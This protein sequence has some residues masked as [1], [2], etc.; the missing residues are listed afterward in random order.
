MNVTYAEYIEI[1]STLENDLN[2]RLRCFSREH[3]SEK[4]KKQYQYLNN[5][6][7]KASNLKF[8][9]FNTNF[10]TCTCTYYNNQITEIFD[11]YNDYKQFGLTSLRNIYNEKAYI[12]C[13]LLEMLKIIDGFIESKKKEQEAIN[14]VKSMHEKA[15]GM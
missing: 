2:E 14:K 9:L 6:G 1:I 8:K 12:S 11:I 5:C 15:K 10:Y 3:S 13:K 7:S 4:T